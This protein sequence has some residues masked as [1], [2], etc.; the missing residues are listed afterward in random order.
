MLTAHEAEV[1]TINALTTKYKDYLDKVEAAVNKAAADGK[2]DARL[3]ISIS[4]KDFRAD[5]FSEVLKRMGYTSG[6]T[7]IGD[8]ENTYMEIRLTWDS[9]ASEKGDRYYGSALTSASQC[10]QLASRNC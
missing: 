2:I 1:N 6:L 3:V 9:N 8:D 5:I 7:F 4:D 10:G